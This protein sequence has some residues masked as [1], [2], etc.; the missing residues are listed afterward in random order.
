M[1]IQLGCCLELLQTQ[2]TLQGLTKLQQVRLYLVQ[3]SKE[4]KFN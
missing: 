3:K 1:G 2:L 4:F